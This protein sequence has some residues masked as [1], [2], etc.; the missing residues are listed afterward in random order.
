MVSSSSDSSRDS[1][2]LGVAV[3][4]D[5]FVAFRGVVA[6]AMDDD[7]QGEREDNCDAEVVLPVDATSLDDIDGSSINE[8]QGLMTIVNESEE[9]RDGEREEER[10]GEMV[11]GLI[12][13]L[14]VWVSGTIPKGWDECVVVVVVVEGTVAE[15]P[16]CLRVDCLGVLVELLAVAVIVRTV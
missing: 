14:E 8:S 7:I 11:E 6:V 9:E 2:L 16:K 10:D 12:D 5:R 4:V 13:K 1:V 3:E 15:R